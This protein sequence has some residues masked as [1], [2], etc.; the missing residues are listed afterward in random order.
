MSVV[1]LCVCLVYGNDKSNPDETL[2]YTIVHVYTIKNVH[3][4]NIAVRNVRLMTL[5]SLAFFLKHTRIFLNRT[6]VF[7]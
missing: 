7:L 3:M 6:P 2:M 5:T 1:V 4:S